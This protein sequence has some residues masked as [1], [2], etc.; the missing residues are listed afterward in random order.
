MISVRL[1]VLPFSFDANFMRNVD[2][3]AGECQVIIST[4]YLNGLV[5][6]TRDCK[7]TFEVHDTLSM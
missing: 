1:L 5:I 2:I 6:R 4:I 7:S 3:A